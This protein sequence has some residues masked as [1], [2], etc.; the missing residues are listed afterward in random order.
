MQPPRIPVP[1]HY[2]DR[3]T[4]HLQKLKSEDIIEDVALSEPIDCVLNVVIS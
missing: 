3:L 2:R 1:Y 4:V